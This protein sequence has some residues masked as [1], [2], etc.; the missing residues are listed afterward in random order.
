LRRCPRGS[1]RSLATARMTS[2]SSMKCW[3]YGRSS[4]AFRRGE[5]LRSGS[6]PTPEVNVKHE[7]RTCAR[8]ARKGARY[9]SRRSGTTADHWQKRRCSD[10]NEY[11]VHRP[12]RHHMA[13][14]VQRF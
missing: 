12:M 11:A 13:D 7:T 4:R 10:S 2:E 14:S 3:P 6:M 8:F 1:I 9:G 5:T